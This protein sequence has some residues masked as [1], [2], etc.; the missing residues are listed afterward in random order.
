MSKQYSEKLTNLIRS[1]LSKTPDDRPSAKEI[2]QNPFIKDNIMQ[3][4]EKTK[5]K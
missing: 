4:L 1:M 2:L 3:L 5:L